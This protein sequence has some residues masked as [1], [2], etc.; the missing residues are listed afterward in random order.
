MWPNPGHTNSLRF[1][2]LASLHWSPQKNITRINFGPR[3]KRQLPETVDRFFNCRVMPV[4]RMELFS[5]PSLGWR[6]ALVTYSKSCCWLLQCP[7]SAARNKKLTG[8]CTCRQAKLTG[9]CTGTA[10]FR[11]CQPCMNHWGLEPQNSVLN[12]Y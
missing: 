10:I 12:S 4:V 8:Y 6:A 3:L 11:T 7:L 2:N 9:T 1:Q 5:T